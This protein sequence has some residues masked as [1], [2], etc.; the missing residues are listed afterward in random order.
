MAKKY[1]KQ[2]ILRAVTGIRRRNNIL[3][4]H[5]FRVAMD[6]PRMKTVVRQIIANDKKVVKW[7]G[8]I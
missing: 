8:R 2:Q 7:M 5:L 3:W 6:D 1:S 4:M